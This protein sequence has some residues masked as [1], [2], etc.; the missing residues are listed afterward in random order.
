MEFPENYFAVYDTARR[1]EEGGDLYHAIKLFKKTIRLA[2]EFSAPYRDLGRIYRSRKEWKPAFYYWKKALSL[3]TEDRE[4]WWQISL[5]AVAL[6]K[7]GLAQSVW[8]KFGLDQM[9]LNQPYGLRLAHDDGYEILWM[10]ALDAGRCRIMS[11]PHPGSQLRYRQT[12]LY[13]QRGE[14]GFSVVGKR[15][16][17]VFDAIDSLKLSP[18]QTFSCLLHTK[19]EK[20]VLQ[21]EK[22]CY[23]AGLGF[24]V[25]SNASRSLTLN[26]AGAFP[27]Y[28]QDIVPKTGDGATLVALA[29]L[30]PAEVE[31]VLNNWQIISL[32]QYSDLRSYG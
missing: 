12:M 18:Y 19:E 20:A 22:L 11:I 25:W 32:G 30:H 13:D 26:Q 28:Y 2:P 15:R 10:Q 31:R 23:E 8:E 6:K 14:K 21:L 5:A 27:E 3:N 17:P 4:S 7:M 1:Y 29:A 16:V 9:D 24:E